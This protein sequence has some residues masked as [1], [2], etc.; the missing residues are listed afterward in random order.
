MKG[1]HDR[2]QVCTFI[3]RISLIVHTFFI[4]QEK[5]QFPFMLVYQQKPLVSA[6]NWPMWYRDCHFM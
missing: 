4:A 6:I 3:H 2:V 1:Y 5:A